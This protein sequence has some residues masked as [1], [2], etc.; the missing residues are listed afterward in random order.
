MR[1]FEDL[2]AG[3]VV[4]LG[5]ISVSEAEIIDFGRRFDPQ[6]FHID[7]AAARE[8]MYGGLIASGWHT[9][10]LFMRL[11]ATGFLNDTASLGS[12]GMDELRWRAPVRPGDTL[13][14]SFELREVR[15][16][17]SRPDRGVL[18][19]SG[20]LRNEETEVLTMIATNFIGRRPGGPR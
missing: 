4:R 10:A 9:C 16:S 15:L 5:T 8:S 2:N 18:T 3:E 17:N 11:L 20:T 14:G 13:T 19:S 7:P 12:P 6:P 1:Y